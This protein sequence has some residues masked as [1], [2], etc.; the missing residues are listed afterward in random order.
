MERAFGTVLLLTATMGLLSPGVATAEEICPEG[1]T[2]NGECV[3]PGLAA[4]MRETAI[5]F[6]QPELSHTA[7]PNFPAKDYIYRY[8]HQ[9]ASTP[10]Q[11]NTEAPVVP[12]GQVLAPI[13][14]IGPLPPPI[15]P[16]SLPCSFPPCGGD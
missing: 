7:Y 10:P 6:S 14:G 4:S 9:I 5:I 12:G 13:S 2:A 8:P 15:V 1:K 3:N 11:V 16:P